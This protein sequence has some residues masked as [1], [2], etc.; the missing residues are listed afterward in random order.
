MKRSSAR[1]AAFLTSGAAIAMVLVLSNCTSSS[2]QGPNASVDSP[3]NASARG[4]ASLPD[5]RETDPA[6]MNTISSPDPKAELA[7]RL[8]KYTRVYYR[9]QAYLSEFDHK[10]DESLAHP[11]A[12]GS[13]S[14][15]IENSPTGASYARLVAA[16]VV[17]EKI[18][19]Q[20]SQAYIGAANAEVA[21]LNGIVAGD[22]SEKIA[23]IKEFASV[24]KEALKKSG[25]QRIALQGVYEEIGDANDE[26]EALLAQSATNYASLNVKEVSRAASDLVLGQADTA[27]Y[28]T[29]AH[30]FVE[31]LTIEMAACTRQYFGVSV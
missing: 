27:S 28:Y 15:F 10:L 14:L 8:D 25:A 21:A 9:A 4:L 13:P 5:P 3:M 24:Y 7:R 17:G 30:K 12:T 22:Q 20:L 29:A 6:A 2:T 18:R 31:V 19:S 26:L 1:S 23:K 11:S 16:W